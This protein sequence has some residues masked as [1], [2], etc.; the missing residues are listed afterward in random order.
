MKAISIQDLK[1]INAKCQ[2]PKDIRADKDIEAAALDTVSWAAWI[3]PN[4]SVPPDT[5]MVLVIIS[6]S[7]AN[8]FYEHAFMT[9]SYWEEDGWLL[10]AD[11][12][13]QFTVEWWTPLPGP[14]ELKDV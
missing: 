5:G 14:P 10:E 9:A 4:E 2:I 7:S 1:R 12:I 6:G 8:T 11:N 3:D 13:D